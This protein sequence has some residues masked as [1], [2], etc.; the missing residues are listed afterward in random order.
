MCTYFQAYRRGMGGNS[1]L[2]AWHA[3]ADGKYNNTGRLKRFL[4]AIGS[5]PVVWLTE[6]GAYRRQST[7]S[8][9]TARFS[10]AQANKDLRWMLNELLNA[11]QGRVKGFFYYQWQGEP[12]FDTGL[13]NRG[14]SNSPRGVYRIYRAATR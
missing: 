7:A 6:Q 3:Y 2:W 11:A 4:N 9:T 1:S 12:K 13:V 5:T 8:G 10:E 14:P